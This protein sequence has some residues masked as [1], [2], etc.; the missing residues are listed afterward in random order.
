MVVLLRML[1]QSLDEVV[2]VPAQPGGSGPA[3]SMLGRSCQLRWPSSRCSPPTAAE[4]V[5]L[6]VKAH[7]S[8]DQQIQGLLDLEHCRGRGLSRQHIMWCWSVAGSARGAAAAELCLATCVDAR[9][10]NSCARLDNSCARCWTR[11]GVL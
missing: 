11:D 10:D 9:L 5:P 2:I 3:A 8:H 7:P 1:P 6:R 4:P